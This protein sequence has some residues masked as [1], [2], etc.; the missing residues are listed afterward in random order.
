ML[1]PV[2]LALVPAVARLMPMPPLPDSLISPWLVTVQ[3]VPVGPLT[4]IA[5]AV[6]PLI[7][8]V[9]VIVAG[10]PDSVTFPE[11]VP[12]IVWVM[13][14]GSPEQRGRFCGR[15]DASHTSG[16][17]ERSTDIRLDRVGLYSHEH[18]SCFRRQPCDRHVEFGSVGSAGFS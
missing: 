3:L 18:Q 5:L 9:L 16:A 11:Y 2:A 13:A 12:A 1:P 6:V 10:L 14:R 4:P 8:A 7:T 15:Y 17:D